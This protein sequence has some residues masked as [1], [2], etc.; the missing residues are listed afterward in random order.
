MTIAVRGADFIASFPVE[1]GSWRR[2]HDIRAGGGLFMPDLGTVAKAIG[3]EEM[4]PLLPRAALRA[5]M[6]GALTEESEGVV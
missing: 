1:R 6:L 4:T 5:R 3:L 2:A